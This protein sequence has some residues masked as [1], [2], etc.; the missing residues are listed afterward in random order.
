MVPFNLHDPHALLG[1]HSE[2]SKRVLR[3]WRKTTSSIFIELFGK[4]IE[5]K[6]KDGTG[7]FEGEVP[8]NTTGQDYRV[9][10]EDGRL[11]RDPYA[12]SPTFG[13]MDAFLFN[14]GVHYKLY[15]A[16]GGRLCVHEGVFGAKFSVWAP[17][18]RAVFLVGDFNHW[19]GT[20]NPMRLIGVSGVFELFVPG[21]KECEKYKFE[22]CTADGQILLKADPY[23]YFSEVRPKTA[24][25][26][27]DVS[28][29]K[30]QDTTWMQE[31]KRKKGKMLV[32]E[33]HLGSWRKGLNYRELAVQLSAYCKEMGFTHVELLPVA[34]HPLDESW[35]YQVTGFYAVTSR[36]GTPEDFQYFVDYLHQQGLGLIVDWVPGHFP[37]DDFSLAK[38]DGSHL[39]EH[40]DPR[41]GLHPHWST[42]IFNYGRK[43]S[44]I[45]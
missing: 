15:D 45:F 11:E 26:L 20:L 33:V 34:E 39:Y 8:L 22:I 19:D 24:S 2:G 6:S 9:Y 7:L 36:F 10:Y 38:F 5:L 17:Q 37:L 31:R 27:F 28:S 14:K 44:Q 1:L 43:R 30:W 16:M 25:M 3:V 40:A 18:A 32:Y 23:A 42:A 4:K 12:F 35:G 21:L 13:E 29:Y 41:Q